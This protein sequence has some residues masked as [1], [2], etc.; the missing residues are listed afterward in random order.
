MSIVTGLIEQLIRSAPVETEAIERAMALYAGAAR[1]YGL[2][3][4][5]IAHG[6]RTSLVADV[7][8]DGPTVVLNGHMDVVPGGPEQFEPVRR[9]G[10]LHGR[11]AYDMLG[12]TAAFLPVMAACRDLRRIKVRL[13]AVPDEETG[14]RLGTGH[15][16]AAGWRGDFVIAGEPTN[17]DIGIQAKGVLQVEVSVGGVSAH[18]SRPWLGQN[19]ILRGYE[20]F[21]HIAGLPFAGERSPLYRGPSLNLAR[22][23]GGDSVNQVP[24]RCLLTL[25][26]RYLPGQDPARILGEIRGVE[27]VEAVAVLVSEPAA[28][29]APEHPA[30][31]ALADAVASATGRR[32]R[33]FGQDGASDVRYFTRHGV[34]GVEFGPSGGGH[35]GPD[36]YLEL[37]SIPVY[38]DCLIGFLHHLDR[39]EHLEEALF[40]GT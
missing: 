21:D 22:I 35:H 5:L 15:L 40:D 18:G 39:T 19:A 9:G 8:G 32:P 13:M 33:L 25:D 23:A 31:Q 3:P 6:G 34:A 12:A 4:R 16:V 30:V 37:D 20:V 2:N 38:I 24:D 29:A 1:Q 11:G 36:E 26:I 17:L 7:G 10:R 27:G 14:G 28:V